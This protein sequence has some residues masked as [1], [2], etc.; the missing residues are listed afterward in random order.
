MRRSVAIKKMHYIQ[1]TIVKWTFDPYTCVIFQ[2][3]EWFYIL[4]SHFLI[5]HIY[6]EHYRSKKTTTKNFAQKVLP[7]MCETTVMPPAGQVPWAQRGLPGQGGGEEGGRPG[8]G[9]VLCWLYKRLQAKAQKPWKIIQPWE[10]QAWNCPEFTH[11]GMQRSGVNMHGGL[12]GPGSRTIVQ[13]SDKDMQIVR[14][15]KILYHQETPPR[16]LE[17][18][19]GDRSPLPPCCDV[20]H[21]KNPESESWLRTNWPILVFV[22]FVDNQ[23][24]II[25]WWL[26][27]KCH[28][29]QNCRE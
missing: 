25:S 4:F 1:F 2:C 3:S 9:G 24:L 10:I 22:C 20:T 26:W 13:S 18:E 12:E 15:W 27:F 23:L 6:K 19:T 21:F 8:A 17:P 16:N 28:M 7:P 11:M 14:P 5:P 29:K